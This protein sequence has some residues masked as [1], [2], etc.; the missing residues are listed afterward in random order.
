MERS[1]V[2]IKPD[3]VKRNLI[4]KIIN[5]YEEEGLVIDELKKINALPWQAEEHYKEHIERPFYP[6]L[7]ESLLSSPIV[8]MVVSG[9][10]AIERIRR[11]N[12]ATDPKKADPETIRGRFGLELP[13]N[14]VHA[15]DA[16]ESADREI[17][18]WFG[19][20]EL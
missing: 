19:E 7:I 4:G 9:D 18:I 15:S 8:A 1:L 2:L 20:I 17:A 16:L 10:N 12:G 6:G 14:T 11:I 13:D 5:A 3:G